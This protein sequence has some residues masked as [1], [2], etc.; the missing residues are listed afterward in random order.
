[1]NA[2]LQRFPFLQRI[3]LNA[4]AVPILIVLILAMMILPLPPLLLDL[5]FTF[6]IAIWR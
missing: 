1:M 2:L 3:G 4:L 5:F 6:N